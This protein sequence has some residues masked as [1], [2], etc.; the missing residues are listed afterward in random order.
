MSKLGFKP[1][2]GL[3]L[4]GLATTVLFVALFVA[5]ITLH[6]AL[7]SFA[8]FGIGFV[9]LGLNIGAVVRGERSFIV[10]AIGAFVGLFLLVFVG[11]EVLFP[12]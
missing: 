10:L 3:G 11:G 9:G 7:P 8:I 5:K 12:H 1:Q 4:L 6:F 2:S